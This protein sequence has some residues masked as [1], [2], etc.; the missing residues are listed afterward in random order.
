MHNKQTKYRIVS[1]V[2]LQRAILLAAVAAYLATPFGA[3]AS[4]ED[5]TINSTFKYAWGENIGWINFGTS[6]GNVHITDSGMTGYAWGENVGWISLNCSNTSSCGTVD[7]GVSNDS[8]GNLTGYA[9]GE[10]TGWISFDNVFSSVNISQT[11]V[12]SAYAWG[13][14]T[15]WIS[16]NC[17]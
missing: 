14:N 12:F 1:I 17:S 7:Y 11:G 10:N 9:W 13:E 15:G 4:S 2:A 6:E 5:G 16:F 8:H 3:G